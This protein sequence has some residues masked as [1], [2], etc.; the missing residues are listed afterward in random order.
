[1]F[2]EFC[3]GLA[4]FTSLGVALQLRVLPYPYVLKCIGW[5]ALLFAAVA[6][7]MTVIPFDTSNLMTW[8][9]LGG[10]LLTQVGGQVARRKWHS[11]LRA[12]DSNSR[13]RT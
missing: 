9:F 3:A 11:R 2:L 12:A 5:L 13:R 7:A 8:G 6:L 4:F 1:M 10:W